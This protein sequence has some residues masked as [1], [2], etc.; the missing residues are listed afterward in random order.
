MFQNVLLARN[1]VVGAWTF[2][3]LTNFKFDS[4]TIAKSGITAAT[5]DF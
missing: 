3:A 1:N 4:L 2:L 5:F